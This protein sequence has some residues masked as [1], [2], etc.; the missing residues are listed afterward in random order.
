MKV[1]KE[2]TSLPEKYDLNQ[3]HKRLQLKNDIIQWLEDNQL[4]WDAGWYVQ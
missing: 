2:H 1:Y 3:P 4:G